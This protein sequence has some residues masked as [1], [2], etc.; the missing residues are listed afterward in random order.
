VN[1]VG[2]SEK[3][4]LNMPIVYVSKASGKIRKN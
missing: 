1:L 2:A 3:Q 4:I